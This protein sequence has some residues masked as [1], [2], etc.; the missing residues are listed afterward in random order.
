MRGNISK[1]RS[2]RGA[3]APPLSS[4]FWV[5][6]RTTKTRGSEP[7]ARHSCSALRFPDPSVRC[8]PSAARGG[9]VTEAELRFEF[10]AF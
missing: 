8:E 7:H 6:R 5:G 3:E 4:E 1:R 9:V 10:L 2:V